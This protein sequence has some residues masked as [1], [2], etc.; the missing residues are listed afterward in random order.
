VA[1]PLLIHGMHG[2][3]DNISQRAIVKRFMRD[4]EVFLRTSW[5]VLNHDLMEQG[6]KCV[7]LHSGLRVQA[8]NE[9]LEADKFVVAPPGIEKIEVKYWEKGPQHIKLPGTVLEEI[10]RLAG[11]KLEPDDTF[12]LTVR[13]AWA[14]Q[15]DDLLEQRGWK[16]Q[17]IL[18]YRPLTKRPE[19]RMN[20]GR[21]PD[22][23][24][25]RDV[26]AQICDRF[27]VVSVASLCD[28]REWLLDATEQ[29]AGVA[30]ITFH[31]DGLSIPLL[32]ALFARASVAYVAA[33]FG[34]ILASAVQTP[35]ISLVGREPAR[36][37]D[38]SRTSPYLGIEPPWADAV[39]RARS[40]LDASVYGY[41]RGIWRH[42]SELPSPR[43]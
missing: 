26:L 25:Y 43:Q 23:Q 22:P 14:D 24:V 36:W 16:G 7:R 39:Q 20:I 27:F 29:A 21:D 38:C 4:R 35:V 10:F 3:G 12:D 33:G 42:S 15:M 40:F 18:V 11:L 13:D 6:L 28:G 5:P 9:T 41:E 37:L 31:G 19:A 2:L 8:K 34:A 32:V 17:P 1:K 30:D